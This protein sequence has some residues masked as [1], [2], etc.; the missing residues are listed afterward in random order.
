MYVETGLLFL[1]D[2]C[3]RFVRRCVEKGREVHQH[4]A[5]LVAL[6]QV[7]EDDHA[8]FV[9]ARHVDHSLGETD[10][11]GLL[12]EGVLGIDDIGG[13]FGVAGGD[14]NFGRRVFGQ[15]SVSEGNTSYPLPG[16]G[17]SG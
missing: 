16:I 1:G 7:H 3:H 12:L 2:A 11:P 10:Q 15:C 9:I 8:I 5:R 14:L 17:K 13:A 4:V 6:P